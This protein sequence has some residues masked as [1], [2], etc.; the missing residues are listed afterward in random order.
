MGT[1]T[2]GSALN[3]QKGPKLEPLIVV[4]PPPANPEIVI[5]G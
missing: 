2:A 5:C 3:S 4:L 1:L